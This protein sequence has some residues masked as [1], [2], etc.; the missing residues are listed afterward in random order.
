[1]EIKQLIAGVGIAAFALS[2]QATTISF[3]GQLKNSTGTALS[4][5]GGTL[6]DA[7]VYGSTLG[8][9]DF[10]VTTGYSN[11][12]NLA[13]ANFSMINIIQANDRNVYQD[14][15]PG[16]GGLGAFTESGRS[17]DSDN[18]NSNLGSGSNFDEILFFN[19][20][21]EVLLNT[22]WFNGNHKETV[23][24]SGNG[25]QFNIFKTTDGNNYS[26]LYGGQQKPTAAEYLAPNLTTA[27]S[28][29]AVAMTGWGDQGGYVEAIQYTSVS[30]PA[31]IA[32]F[33]LGLA[34][35]GFTRRKKNFT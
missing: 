26:S 12:F 28:Q 27:Y 1:M 17:G 8:F 3:D 32:L 23:N 31:T 19:F 5:T 13:F 21:Q 25:A 35:L 9:G 24:T 15:N 11:N 14:I 34:G 18:L 22:F 10:T 16:N 29:F 2:V 6:L 4:G 30:A 20:N 33:G 7:D